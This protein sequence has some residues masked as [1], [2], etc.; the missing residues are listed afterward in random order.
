[1]FTYDNLDKEYEEDKLLRI[2]DD[3]IKYI[4]MMNLKNVKYLLMK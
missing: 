2:N 1:M 3:R 4:C